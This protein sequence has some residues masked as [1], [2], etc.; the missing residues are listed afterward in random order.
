MHAL[1]REKLGI[2]SFG[3][4]FPAKTNCETLT[5]RINYPDDPAAKH[6]TECMLAQR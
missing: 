5:V 3:L 6:T 4:P 2:K 1:K